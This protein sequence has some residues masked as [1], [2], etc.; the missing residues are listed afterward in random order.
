[1]SPIV[2]VIVPTKNRPAELADA[3]GSVVAQ[4]LTDLEVIVINDGGVDVGAV[5]ERFEPSVRVQL[6]DRAISGGPAQA[7]NAGLEAATGE[8][9]SFLD[10]DDQYLPEHL[11]A[12]VEAAA[13]RTADLVY[14]DAQIR[15]RR[16]D[17][18]AE[19]NRWAYD[20]TLVSGFLEVTSFIPPVA[21]VYRRSEA[22]FDQGLPVCEDWE[23]WLQLMRG[24]GYRI[25]RVPRI[26]VIYHRVKENGSLTADADDNL[27]DFMPFFDSYRKI[28]ERWP[29]PEISR[30][31][32][33][34][35]FMIQMHEMVC[36]HLAAGDN[37]PHLYYERIFRLLH[38]GFTQVIPDKE[39]PERM[40]RALLGLP[41]DLPML[42]EPS[43]SLVGKH[44]ET[45][46]RPARHHDT[47]RRI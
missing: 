12:A 2:S 3:L 29:V 15:T 24:H 30:M 4:T 18:S 43:P 31:H 5:V 26:G 13:Q 9:I 45:L 22:R 32:L 42:D 34:R 16:G 46:I 6:I 11:Q 25:A 40:E 23:M 44:A 28:C 17:T 35:R 21:A 20:I 47:A 7:R 38:A 39:M 36:A 37:L 10:D 1:M 19:A 14:C 8:F 33:Y 41:Q 27:D